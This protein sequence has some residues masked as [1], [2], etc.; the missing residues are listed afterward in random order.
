MSV[1]GPLDQQTASNSVFRVS[2][3]V[4]CI[5]NPRRVIWRKSSLKKIFS[6]CSENMI[7]CMLRKR[8]PNGV[9]MLAASALSEYG[10]GLF[11]R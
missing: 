5:V 10:V 7:S 3:S 4:E 11:T 8:E 2:A 9:V 1:S 6:E